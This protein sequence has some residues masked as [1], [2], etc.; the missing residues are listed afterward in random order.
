MEKST[1]VLILLL[2]FILLFATHIQHYTGQMVKTWFERI[3]YCADSDGGMSPFINGKVD[4]PYQSRMYSYTDTCD[5]SKMWEG[6]CDN[7]RLLK[8][9]F[10]CPHG[11]SGHGADSHGACICEKDKECPLGYWCNNGICYTSQ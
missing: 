11:C 1:L 6:T 10:Q 7:G 9:E 3:T 8:V 5:G 2:I 4:Y